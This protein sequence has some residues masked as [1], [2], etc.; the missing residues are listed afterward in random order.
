MQA[1]TCIIWKEEK[2]RQIG[3]IFCVIARSNHRGRGT[4]S[5]F[6]LWWNILFVLIRIPQ[7][8]YASIKRN[9]TCKYFYMYM[10]SIREILNWNYEVSQT[11]FFSICLFFVMTYNKASQLYLPK[12]LYMVY[13]IYSMFRFM[14]YYLSMKLN[15]FHFLES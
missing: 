4:W 6:C 2:T 14:S 7:R 3:S 8:L 12:K 9:T 10:G 1:H 11:W 15:T 5:L 13:G